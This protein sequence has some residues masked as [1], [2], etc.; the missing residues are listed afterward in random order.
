[1]EDRAEQYF[2]EGVNLAKLGRFSEA[3][4]SFD[5]TIAIKQDYTD[6]WN[7]RGNA[8]NELGQYSEAVTSFDKALTLKPDHT[9]AWTFRGYALNSLGQYTGAVASC[10]KAL[11]LKPDDTQ[12]LVVRGCALLLLGLPAQALVSFDNAIAKEPDN[13]EARK[14]RENA[15]KLIES[16]NTTQQNICPHCGALITN[17]QN[18]YCPKCLQI[19]NNLKISNPTSY[20]QEYRR[21]CGN[22]GK[23]WHSLVQREKKIESGIQFDKTFC[24][25]NTCSGGKSSDAV[26]SQSKRNIDAQSSTL[27]DLRKCPNCGSINY[28]EEILSYESK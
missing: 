1:M 27:D 9:E 10:D 15:L 22:C 8:L 12:A 14:Y 11:A 19:V 16:K 18:P 23:V 3:V 21:T 25:C 26:I 2:T 6:A 4:D 17:P 24:L 13:A 7:E 28:N 5:K 20:V